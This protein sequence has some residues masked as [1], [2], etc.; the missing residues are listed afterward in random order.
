MNDPA[1]NHEHPSTHVLGASQEAFMA[2][3]DALNVSPLPALLA[4]DDP[5]P[6]YFVRRDLLVVLIEVTITFLPGGS[7]SPETVFDWFTLLEGNWFP[8]L[9][10][11]GV[12]NTLFAALG[13]PLYLGLYAAHQREDRTYAAPDANA[14][15][16]EENEVSCR[17]THLGGNLS[18]GRTT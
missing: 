12:L 3:L 16:T 15:Q 13:I 14:S 17:Q 5:T 10:T 2:K 7:A 18:A 8:G 1:H 6:T 4:S 9:R 11:L